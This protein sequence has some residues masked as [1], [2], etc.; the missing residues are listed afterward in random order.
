VTVGSALSAWLDE[1]GLG[2][3]L[4]QVQALERWSGAVGPQIAAVTRPETVN[5]Q[6]V[7]WVRVT[8]SAW[9]NELSLMSRRILAQV[10]RGVVPKAQ[11]REIRWLVGI[12]N[13]NRE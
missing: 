4:E 11:I 1:A 12:E 8:T 7:L 10:N 6:G 9:A 2:A 5:A 13:R 3:R